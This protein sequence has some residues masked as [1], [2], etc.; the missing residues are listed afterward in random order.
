MYQDSSLSRDEYSDLSAVSAIVEEFLGTS[1]LSLTT[2][3]TTVSTIVHMQ[4]M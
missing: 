2:M 3:K 1:L 4:P